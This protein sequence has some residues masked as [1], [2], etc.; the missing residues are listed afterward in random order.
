MD[1]ELRADGLGSSRGV[2][3]VE[4]PDDKRIFARYVHDPAQILPAGG[5]KLLISAHEKASKTQRTK[6]VFVTDCDYEVRRGSLRGSPDLVI[7]TL[8]DMES[9]LLSLGVIEP[10]V[11]ELVP[12]ALES[13]AACQSIARK[14]QM[15]AVRI[16]VPIGRIRMA[17]QP[18]GIPIDWN[19]IKLSRYWDSRLGEMNFPRLVDATHSKVS[20][21]IGFNEWRALAKKAPGDAGMCHGKD[22]V[23]AIA[24]LLKTEFRATGVTAETL[25]KLIRTSLTEHHLGT[26]D[27]IRRIKAWQL[28]NKRHVLTT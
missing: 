2:L 16:A 12:Q 9:D 23:R 11:L 8:T 26:W 18:L 17:A 25:T 6:L 15:R 22:L 4:G 13:R 1:A 14:L 10:L 27:V 19:D 7:T 3:V 5:R 28:Q 21:A 20:T 24:F